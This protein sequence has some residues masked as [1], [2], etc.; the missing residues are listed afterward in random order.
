MK[1]FTYLTT[2]AI[3]MFIIMAFTSV[4]RIKKE[5]L[6]TL[7]PKTVQ[8]IKLPEITIKAETISFPSKSHFDFLNALGHK[9]SGNNYKVVNRFGY[10]GRYQFGKSTLK[11][12]GYNITSEQFINSPSIQEEAMHKLLIHNKT[13]L[14][15][16]IDKYEGDTVHGVYI[17]ES[18]ILAAAHLGGVGNV[19][20]FFRK[21]TEF[22]DGFGTTI[23]SYMVKF[24]G[25][26]LDI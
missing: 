3:I 13:K 19:R 14:Q 4:N 23:T 5:E 24:S 10:L 7:E 2:Y 18:G 11:G 1:N 9:E 12:L 17:T 25:Y 21:G 15:K 22:K 20:K 6:V 26:E 8:L 16:Y